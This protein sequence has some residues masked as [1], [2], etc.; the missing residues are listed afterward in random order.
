MEK[1]L[2]K[3]SNIGCFLILELNFKKLKKAVTY[4]IHIYS[5]INERVDG[6]SKTL[7]YERI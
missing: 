3:H 1:K 2:I 7:N 5:N 4:F 6:L